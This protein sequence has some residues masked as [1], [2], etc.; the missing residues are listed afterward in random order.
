VITG[1]HNPA[2]D[3]VADVLERDLPA[4]R[5]VLPGE[6]HNLPRAP[7]YNEALAAFLDAA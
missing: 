5:V 6:R 7:G 2:L 3:A 4:E 1:A